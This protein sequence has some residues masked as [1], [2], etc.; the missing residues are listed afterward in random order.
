MKHMKESHGELAIKR[1]LGSQTQYQE[2]AKHRFTELIVDL[3]EADIPNK[4]EA[5]NV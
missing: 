1:P 5:T 3:I 4:K 2:H